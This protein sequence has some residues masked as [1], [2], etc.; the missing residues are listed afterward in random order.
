M[1]MR[2]RTVTAITPV[3]NGAPLIARTVE[4][5][6]NQSAVK[7]GRLN[8]TYILCDGASTD[9][10]VEAARAASAG[11]ALDVISEPD[12]GMYDAL[13]HGLRR[14]T[15]DLVF[16]LN[17]GDMLFSNALDVV[18]DVMETHDVRW[19]TGYNAYFN[20]AGAVVGARLPFRFRPALMQRGAY[21]T[22]LPMVQQESTFW[23]RDMLATVD[24][25]KLA[26]YRLAG[27]HY[28]WHQFSTLEELTIAKVFLGGFSY[29]GNHL[30]AAIDEYRREARCHSEKLSWRTRVRAH[31]DRLLWRVPGQLKERANPRYLLAYDHDT[32]EWR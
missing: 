32:H 14:A 16:Y 17:A 24:L 11:A 2:I 7:S 10:T 12:T 4:S 1:L 27:D 31:A 6:V 19:V 26:T 9:G 30:S 23:H 8:L 13:A 25:Q 29:H 18:A 15:G 3:R 28:L 20:A 21:G 22:I 5:I